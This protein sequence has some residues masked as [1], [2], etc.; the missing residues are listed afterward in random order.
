M[1]VCVCADAY[2]TTDCEA[3][4]PYLLADSGGDG[5]NVVGEVWAVNNEGLR[6]LDDYEGVAVCF[7]HEY[8]EGV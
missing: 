8:I 5:L 4:V 6:G 2:S 7:S 1:C 3:G